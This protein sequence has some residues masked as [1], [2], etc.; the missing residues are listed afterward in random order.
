MKHAFETRQIALNK[1]MLYPDNVG[2]GIGSG[3]GADEIASLAANIADL[4]H[5]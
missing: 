4:A 1:Q 3:Y 5:A 2:A